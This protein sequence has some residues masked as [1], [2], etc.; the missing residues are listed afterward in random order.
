MLDIHNYGQLVLSPWGHQ[1]GQ[2]P[3]PDRYVFDAQNT[4]LELLIEGV[5]GADYLSGPAGP[6]QYIAS[7]DAPDWHYGVQQLLAWTIELRPITFS[8]GFLIDPSQIVPTGQEIYPA[9]LETIRYATQSLDLRLNSAPNGEVAPSTPVV[10]TFQAHPYPMFDAVD[11]A[12]SRVEWTNLNTLQ[13][14]SVAWVL[15]TPWQYSAT[16][17]GQPA[18]SVVEYHLV[19]AATL[20]GDVTT[21]PFDASTNRFVFVVDQ[22]ADLNND[23]LVDG[24]DLGL[25]LGNWGLPGLGD[26]NGDGLVDGADLGLLLGSWGM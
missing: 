2:T 17:P 20:G 22:P 8:P 13:N 26:L 23:G 4:E 6:L 21:L 24:S 5:F 10:I 18:G 12:M 7:G 1:S 16:I 14:G 9:A 15:I 3:E 11:E 19:S 25:M